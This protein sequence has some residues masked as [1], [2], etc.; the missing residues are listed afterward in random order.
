MEFAYVQG[1][2]YEYPVIEATASVCTWW[3]QAQTTLWYVWLVT[4]VL[5][6]FEHI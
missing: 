2:L 3:P 4:I 5:F 1:V 6:A